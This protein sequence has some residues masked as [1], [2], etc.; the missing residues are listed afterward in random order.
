MV[1]HASWTS[2][3]DVRANLPTAPTSK[4]PT[5]PTVELQ[6]RASVQQVTGED[7]DSVTLTLSTASPTVGSD[8]P[9]LEPLRIRI[10]PTYMQPVTIMAGGYPSRRSR[11]SSRRSR[12]RDRYR[13]R[14]RS[15]RRSP[16]VVHSR[17]FIDSDAEE[18]DE[19]VGP[20]VHAAPAPPVVVTEGG[21]SLSYAIAGKST[22]TSDPSWHRVSIAVCEE[23]TI[24]L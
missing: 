16:V 21:I 8:I 17:Q 1:T 6:Y 5:S 23:R 9:T 24:F 11:S 7:W 3:Y 15:P 2:L 20:V 22:I 19:D 18:S 12:S 13:S 14:S 4:S 10:K